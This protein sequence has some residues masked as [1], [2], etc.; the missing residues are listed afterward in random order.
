MGT[1]DLRTILADG[2]ARLRAA[3]EVDAAAATTP[4]APTTGADRDGLVEVV[5]DGHGLL[6]DIAFDADVARLT[7][8]QL[9]AA[10]L[11]AVREA[12]RATGRAR[13]QSLPAL[14]DSEFA[15]RVRAV[16]AEEGE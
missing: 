6:A 4:Q 8:A 5:V 10:V 16:L 13:V 15:A 14:G 9:E 3:H 1:E 2:R 12:H 7:P 11:D